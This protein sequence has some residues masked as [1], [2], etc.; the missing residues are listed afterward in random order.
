MIESDTHARL[1][2][3]AVVAARDAVLAKLEDVFAGKTFAGGVYLRGIQSATDAIADDWQRWLDESLDELAARA[4]ESLDESV[5]RPLSVQYNPRGVHHVDHLLGAEVFDLGEDNWQ[6]HTLSSPVG[7]LPA[8]DL[9]G[10]PAWRAMQ[11]YTRA[12]VARD[13]PGVM[14]SM[15]TIAS[16]LNVAIWRLN[17]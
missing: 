3:P 16:V 5:L 2:D 12:F 9:A 15:P 1:N 10:R 4:D 7:E 11:D 8:V 14:L 17:A 13:A 6:C